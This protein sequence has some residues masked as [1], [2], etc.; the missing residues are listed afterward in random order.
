MMML[1]IK[2]GQG[3]G[4]HE[5]RG[6]AGRRG[7]SAPDRGR[8]LIEQA[9]RDHAAPWRSVPD[10]LAAWNA[11]FPAGVV[12][13]PIG[14]VKMGAAQ[15]EKLSSR[16]RERYFGL[17]KPTLAS[18]TYIVSEIE[19]ADRMTERAH[20]GESATRASVIKFI[21]AFA[22]ANGRYHGFMCVTIDRDGME[23]AVSASPRKLR[24]LARA[25]K[26]GAILTAG[27]SVAGE[28]ASPG[29][30]DGLA[31][32]ASF[33]KLTA[34]HAQRN[35]AFV[36]CDLGL[37]GALFGVAPDSGLLRK[38]DGDIP[39]GAH[40]ITAHPNG[41]G[42]KGTPLLIQET[43]QGSGAFHVIGGAGGKLNY[44]R[45]RP[46]QDPAKAHEE[47]AARRKAKAQ[48]RRERSQQEDKTVRAAKRLQ[49]QDVRA[50]RMVHEQALIQQ[51]AGA[52][53]WT[54][55]QFDEAAHPNLSD[56]A[57][58]AARRKHHREWLSKAH[59]VVNRHKQAL[60]QDADARAQALG[61]D[62]LEVG[63]APLDVSDLG[64]EPTRKPALGARVDYT[65]E[66]EKRGASD[67]A[68][69]REAAGSALEPDE[70]SVKRK[71]SAQKIA[72]ELE[73]F[74][75]GAEDAPVVPHPVAP[76]APHGNLDTEALLGLV[77]AQ[78][79]AKNARKAAISANR[80]IE[81]DRAPKGAYH[82]AVSDVG[83][84]D[85]RADL[86][87]DL[88]TA[89]TRA[90]LSEV[91]GRY[92]A[93]VDR[94]LGAHMVD[95]A[96]GTIN[97]LALAVT[98]AP[99]LDRMVVDT[100]GIAGAAQALAAKLKGQMTRDELD[101]LRASLGD[102]HA[103][104][105][106]AAT[107]SALKEA[108]VAEAAAK[109][110][111]IDSAATGEDLE[112]LKALVDRREAAASKA[113]AILGRTLGEM[114]ANAA[115]VAAFGDDGATGPVSLPL[116]AMSRADAITRARAIG[117]E[118]GDYQVHAAGQDQYLEVTPDGLGKLAHPVRREDLERY[119]ESRAILSGERDEAGWL[120]R[121]IADRPDLA[122]GELQPGVAPRLAEP[123]QAGPDLAQSIRD[124]IGG[125][126]ADG[127]APADILADL[128]SGPMAEQSGDQKAYWQAL[129]S[130]VP[131]NGPDGKPLLADAHADAFREMADAFVARRHGNAMVPLHR[132][133][134]DANAGAIDA[135][136]RA[137]TE[138]PEGAAAFKPLGDLT[139]ADRKGL[140]QWWER[141]VG[142]QDGR[143]A[144]LAEALHALEAAEPP[145][146]APSLFGDDD[147]NPEWHAWKRERD[148]K[149]AELNAAGLNW[150]RY[151]EG[152]GGPTKAME[153]VQ[154]LVRGELSRRFA[155]YH[156]RLN[157]GA[158]LRVGRQS[159]AHGLDHLDMIDPEARAARQKQ[160][161]ELIDDLR[162]RDQGRY[163]S[164][165]VADKLTDAAETRAA[166]A[167]GQLDMFG[168]AAP[169]EA[170]DA[171]LGKDQR[172]TLGHAAE[173]QLAGLMQ[174]VGQNFR[175]G[176]QVKLWRPSMDGKYALG[177]RAIKFIRA[178]KRVALGLGTGTGKTLTGLGAFTDLHASGDVKKG[179][180]VVPSSVQGQFH[181]EALRYLEP[182]KYQWHAQPGASRKERLRA[183]ADPNT[184]FVVTTHQA[185]RNDLLH[186]GAKAAGIEPGEMAARLDAMTAG[187]RKQWAAEVL[188]AHGIKPDFVMADEAH[189]ALNRQGKDNSTL[190][191]VLDAVGHNA[192]YHVLASADPVKNDVSEVADLLAKLD[193]TRYGDRDAF[194]R[195]YGGDTASKKEALRREL[196][197]YLMTGHN[198][199]DVKVTRREVSVP[200][201]D[202]HA[203]ALA[204]ID[205]HVAAARL[206]RIK[207]KPDIGALKALS[208]GAFDGAEEADHPAIAER[209]QAS[210][211]VLKESAYRR[212]LDGAE[213]PK[214]DTLAKL[215]KER[216]GTPGVVFAHSLDAARAIHERLTKDG[217]RAALLTGA[218]S[219][220]ERD[221]IRQGFNPERGDP[222]HDILVMS[223][224]GAVGINAQ[225]GQWLAQYDTPVTAMA[226]AQR[227]GRINRLGQRNDVELIDLVA[228][229]PAEHRA[230]ERLRTKYGLREVMTD[231]SAGLDDTGVA[232]YLA[233]RQVA[234]DAAQGGLF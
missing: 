33:L 79:V 222:K 141:N 168:F 41:P 130:V 133:T 188:E 182:G 228:D 154:D 165:R 45:I 75:S 62:P 207:G 142:S 105:Y 14:Q 192:S 193:P 119:R 27:S 155:E 190:A 84:D 10:S 134:I 1:L 13:T 38:A 145:K 128:H 214:L 137:L 118:P 109:E 173:R 126:A 104:H 157:A 169:E 156:N 44:L 201:A 88:R 178:N 191:N 196:T 32:A 102:Y 177:Q 51:V 227:Q 61:H 150:G 86:M 92:G 96:H 23:I 64:L 93:S 4:N 15:R 3:S 17:I 197:P 97:A 34:F 179:L 212:A 60:L 114:E 202:K 231:P 108:R 29:R 184:H 127:D 172:H 25:V 122:M 55:H 6:R 234:R 39:A 110:I 117:L 121:G 68:I 116:G 164:G 152:M 125:R 22:D 21:R 136:H 158:P 221:A 11:E 139:H 63:G 143:G 106:L 149:A 48:A 115:L 8:R 19:T 161:R 208:P 87:N 82:L 162:E 52:M 77:R 195:R 219:A 49:R 225:R 140:R 35:L 56:N 74:R 138:T 101:D 186:L 99:L 171:P 9:L 215:A 72:A 54:G 65:K 12:E 58:D 204:K 167:Q 100:L 203:K 2:G 189:G 76:D 59:A 216:K 67:E 40:W 98:G 176:D 53:G 213:S 24:Q 80:E 209:L 180:F 111:D 229:H 199:P 200:V 198:T 187:E 26:E 163:A 89:S 160:Q 7:G 233:R 94:T 47:A 159:I 230:R 50:Q 144:K 103:D 95:G 135:L 183:M 66:A 223:D 194:L 206:G 181:G 57:L 185:L 46:S 107:E 112:T 20:R 83:L 153:A 71:V 170:K 43:H 218:H 232:A 91:G 28:A 81:E 210:L 220:A 16:Q 30:E 131:R 5:H 146:T 73:G 113:Q 151:V 217:H 37:A 166:A 132:Q 69:A 70:S 129:D 211:G 90:F 205:G 120:P 42:T 78:K 85:V 226:H 148:A 147:P 123:F 18:P 36:V 174:H 124:Y 31:K 175:P 224:A